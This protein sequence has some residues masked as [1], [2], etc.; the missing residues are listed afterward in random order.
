[1]DRHAASAIP[2]TRAPPVPPGWFI[3]SL[4]PDPLEIRRTLL[5]MRQRFD[6]LSGRETA[7]RMELVVAEILNN[8]AEHGGVPP[9]APCPTCQGVPA[10]M[11][12]VSAATAQG[13]IYCIISDEG[14]AVPAHCLRPSEAPHRLPADLR[15]LPEG[16]FGWFMIQ[17]VAR[18]LYYDREGRRNILAFLIP[19]DQ[20][21]AAA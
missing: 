15:D 13:G 10:R 6:P 20:P 5:Q 18:K 14:E 21:A 11:I 4:T 9:I 1:M 2:V 16:G 17:N 12:H 8:I 3:A 7:A 19:H